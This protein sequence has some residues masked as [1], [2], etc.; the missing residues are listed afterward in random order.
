MNIQAENDYLKQLGVTD[1]LLTKDELNSLDRDGY[2]SLGCLLDK[3]QLSEILSHIDGVLELEGQHAGSELYECK[4]IR[5]PSEPGV[6]RL[7]DLV[8][9]GKAF[10]PFYT[11][12]K[13]L[14]ATAHVLRNHFKLSSLNYRAA[15]PGSGA[16]QLHVDWHEAVTP[17]NYQVCNS[18]WLLDDFTEDN[19]A[20]RLV[21][22]THL[23]NKRPMEALEDP[24]ASHPLEQLL[25]APAGTVV[26][27]NSHLW[28][29]GTINNTNIQRR[30][31]HSYY[32]HYD[33]A[34]QTDQS[35]YIRPETIERLDEA[36]LRL[37]SVN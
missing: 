2:V 5:H 1:T 23:S 6:T 25:L 10:D 22:S 26:V 37:L 28:H 16:Q 32:C 8:N 21:P 34:Q 3:Q 7:A 15:L 9:K 20:T 19:G 29:G 27:F 30:A 13:V 12:P 14:A 17:G 33:V 35:R 4:N 24:S 11:H 31:I 18:I 36:V